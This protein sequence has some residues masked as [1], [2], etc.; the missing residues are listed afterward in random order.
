MLLEGQVNGETSP[1]TLHVEK[2]PALS[3]NIS[4]ETMKTMVCSYLLP[5]VACWKNI[6]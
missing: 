2:Y 1:T 6:L 4:V 5:A 3:K